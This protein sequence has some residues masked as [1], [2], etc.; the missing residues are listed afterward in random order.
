MCIRIVDVVTVTGKN[1]VDNEYYI[2]KF[3][4]EFNNDIRHL[5]EDVVGR[6]ER[7]IADEN[8]TTLTMA[9]EAVDKVLE[10]NNLQGSDI[11]LIVFTSQLPEYT[12]PTQAVLIHR[13][14]KGKEECNVMDL[15]VA[16]VGM[17]RG[18]ELC[19]KYVSDKEANINKILLIGSDK[20]SSHSQSDDA[21]VMTAFGDGAC[22]VLL[23]RTEE[24]NWVGSANIT[25]SEK[26]QMITFPECGMSNISNYKDD[27]L[28]ISWY[29]IN[30]DKELS[31]M[32]RATRKVLDR[33]NINVKDIDWVCPSQFTQEV[34]KKVSDELNVP[35]EKVI[36]VGDKYGYTGTSSPFFAFKEGIDSGKIKRGDMILFTSIGLGTTVCSILMKY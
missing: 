22:A 14:I 5:V 16:C 2:N 17:L 33:Y 19:K 8:Q 29:G 12:M 28:K 1:K 9:A 6:K 4:E 10:N 11:D 25:M 21:F 3:K 27:A 20:V 13:H 23:E 15:N 32:N 24:E 35:I 26:A 34:Y 36:Y 7:Y 18:L 30:V 31:S